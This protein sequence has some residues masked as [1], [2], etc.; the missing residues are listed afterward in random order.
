MSVLTHYI[1]YIPPHISLI[2]SQ[3][4]KS[5]AV[6]WMSERNKYVQIYDQE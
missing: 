5:T 1:Y 3:F 6:F 2:K 4:E